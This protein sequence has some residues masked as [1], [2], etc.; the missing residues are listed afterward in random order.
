M[1]IYERRLKIL[2]QHTKHSNLESSNKLISIY[3][4]EYYLH[5]SMNQIV[6]VSC[7]YVLKE[8][9]LLVYTAE[10][11]NLDIP[12][13]PYPVSLWVLWHIDLY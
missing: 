11:A 9:E 2:Y 6:S 3:G 10:C 5:T 7:M 13:C 12:F 4:I 8:W 1:Y